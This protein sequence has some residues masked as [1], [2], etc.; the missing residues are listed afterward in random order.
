ML[1]LNGADYTKK[2]DK[3][4]SVFQEVTSKDYKNEEIKALIVKHELNKNNINIDKYNI[5]TTK[6]TLLPH[7]AEPTNPKEVI[8]SK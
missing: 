8:A 3:G 4:I 1:L 6:Q 2:N 5:A 7:K